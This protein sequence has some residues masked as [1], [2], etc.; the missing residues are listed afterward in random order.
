MKPLFLTFLRKD[1]FLLFVFTIQLLWGQRVV[2]YYPQWIQN[3]F[4][5]N[6]IDLTVVS[7]VIHAF[8]WP[9]EQ[10]NVLSYA[11]M[12]NEGIN[13]TIH[14]GGGLILLALGGWGNSW[15]FSTVTASPV[16][17]ETFI[18]NLVTVCELYDYDGIDIDWEFPQ[19]NIEKANLSIFA[20]ELR[21][22]FNENHPDWIISIAVPISNW[23]GQ[24]FD[25]DELEESVDFFNAM[26]YDIHGSWSSHTGHNAPL[27]PSP[28]NDPD[29]S[30]H[31]GINYLINTRGV[32]PDMIN[33]GIPFYGKQYNATDINQ[34]FTGT[35]LDKRYY[36]VQG[37]IETG[38][39]YVWDNDGQ[40]PY[41]YNNEQTKVITFDDSLAVSIK[42]EY[43]IANNLG[44]LMIWALG[45]DKVDLE[46]ELIE[47]I[48]S[49]F[50]R[51]DFNDG[52]QPDQT[53]IAINNFP[54]PFNPN[55]T[56]HTFIPEL[57]FY[58][59]AIYSIL[60]QKISTLFQGNLQAG[61]HTFHWRGIDEKQNRVSNGI[62]FL[63]VKSRIQ[64][65]THKIVV[66]K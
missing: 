49:N 12:M 38:W 26:T 59:I 3:S 39:N 25:F 27:Y 16:L 51:I 55:T 43:A 66:L 46:Q 56:I 29:G 14:E 41:T 61:S 28:P 20:E 5:P 24:Y 23:T 52:I 19:N 9:D 22:V 13:I 4:Q 45:Y 48:H 37:L 11:N 32:S 54:N 58:Q 57:G 30:V 17:R 40:V 10:G 64:S 15:G 42:S 63:Q 44:G 65:K 1:K 8:A 62:Y 2:G 21:T 18:S 60:G 50:L 7:H 34:P 35:V 31:T 47:A 33:L 53:I 6:E 36:E